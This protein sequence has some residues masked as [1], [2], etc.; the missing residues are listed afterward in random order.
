M[1]TPRQSPHRPRPP[2]QLLPPSFD[3]PITEF[4]STT[5]LRCG[6]APN[7]QIAAFRVCSNQSDCDIV[8]VL[9]PIRGDGGRGMSDGGIYTTDEVDDAWKQLESI[10]VK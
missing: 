5:F 9:Q 3:K 8:G 1:A 4:D 6:C 10:S 2:D 7:N